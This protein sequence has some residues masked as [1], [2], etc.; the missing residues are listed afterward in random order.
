MRLK[1]PKT[2]GM[3]RRE[4]ASWLARLQ[5]GREPEVEHK[6]R[7]W[8][9]ADPAHAAAFDRVK[10]SYEQA[11]LLRQSASANRASEARIA[12]PARAPRYA[13]AAA[14]ALAAVV[15]V[16]ILV[17]G[18]APFVSDTHAVMLVTGVGE[19][20]R[21]AL[22]DG[23]EVTL[24]TSTSLKVEI[25]RSLRRAQLQKGRARF[26]IAPGSTPFIVEAGGTTITSAASAFDVELAGP[27]SRVEL[28]AG[29]ADVLG[30]G[31]P[32]PSLAVHAGETV[33]ALPSGIRTPR[34]IQ[35]S[36]DGTPLEA[37]VELANRYSDR[38]IVL[39]PDLAALRVTGAFRAGDTQGLA[40]ALARAFDLSL[41]ETPR[42]LI[43]AA[44][45]TSADR[46]NKNGG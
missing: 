42:M 40:R 10:R 8:C 26:R 17:S 33:A 41:R 19:I 46:S 44:R 12:R 18:R 21:V 1:L 4:A 24:D 34:D 31:E 29:T 13:L 14:A 38:Q 6:L 3:L 9:E 16:A 20:R 37:A 28:L 22:E 36:G 43:L 45:K 7:K 23:S 27:G 32:R 39:A 35:P 15:P 30:P 5:S 2:R 25:G 11:G